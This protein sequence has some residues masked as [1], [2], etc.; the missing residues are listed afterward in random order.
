MV[1]QQVRPRDGRRCGERARRPRTLLIITASVVAAGLVGAPAV[2][3]L[4]GSLQGSGPLVWPLPLHVK[5]TTRIMSWAPPFVGWTTNSNN[6]TYLA[7]PL[8]IN[9]T[10]GDVSG[11]A[12]VSAHGIVGGN[13]TRQYNWIGVGF[14]AQSPTFTV[15]QGGAY[16]FRSLWE[17]AWN[18]SATFVNG[19]KPGYLYAEFEVQFGC[20]AGLLDEATGA[21]W[22]ANFGN[23][24][25]SRGYPANESLN[26]SSN[27]WT[28][29]PSIVVLTH[30]DRYQLNF[31]C[32]F[33]VSTDAGP[34]NAYANA[35]FSFSYGGAITKLL[36]IRL[37]HVS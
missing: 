3:A 22:G 19:V 35:A 27:Q 5:P 31:G 12:N 9:T 20:G 26:A 6:N 23:T 29:L 32:G 17:Q 34:G 24:T 28:S 10:T 36:E 13:A 15:A 33:L 11:K 2:M 1:A 4:S 18:W 8:L 7:T 25:W 14:G 37:T 21:S 16:V 30:G